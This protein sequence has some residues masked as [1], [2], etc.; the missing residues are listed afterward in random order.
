VLHF[1][2]LRRKTEIGTIWDGF[3][4]RNK[5]VP[6]CSVIFRFK[7]AT[8]HKPENGTLWHGSMLRYPQFASLCFGMLRFPGAIFY[9]WRVS[10]S[11]YVA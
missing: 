5:T 3:A 8:E 9:N 10:L 4:K 7:R 1:P 2:S 6:L 11:R